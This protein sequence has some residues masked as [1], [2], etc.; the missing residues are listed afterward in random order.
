MATKKKLNS[1]EHAVHRLK[2]AIRAHT[3]AQ[4]DLSWKGGQHP[5][6]R[7][8]IEQAAKEA[9]LRLNTVINEL[10]IHESS[11]RWHF[12]EDRPRTAKERKAYVEFLEALG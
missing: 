10:I 12:G 5:H 2:R 7:A 9:A 3:R 4:I 6:D 1:A 11:Y 8:G